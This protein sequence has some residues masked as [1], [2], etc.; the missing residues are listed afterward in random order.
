MILVHLA[1]DFR[2][3]MDSL[4]PKHNEAAKWPPCLGLRTSP[5]LLDVAY[6]SDISTEFNIRSLAH[7]SNTLSSI[8]PFVPTNRLLNLLYIDLNNVLRS[9]DES[10]VSPWTKM[11]LH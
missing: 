5:T 4:R 11:L 10:Y 9:F 3:R 1:R 7:A 6:F 2:H 8:S